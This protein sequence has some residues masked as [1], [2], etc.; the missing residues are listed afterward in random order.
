[1]SQKLSVSLSPIAPWALV[2]LAA[3]AVVALTLWPY[4]R[5]IRESTDR[6]R[7]AVI[8]LRMTAVL[9]CFLAMLRPSVLLLQKV[10]QQAVVLFL[11]DSSSSMKIKD[12]ANNASRWTAARIAAAESQ[13]ALKQAAPSLSLKTYRFDSDV[14]SDSLDDNQ[15]PDGQ[16]TALGAALLEAVKR[17]S[18]SRLAT[19]VLFSDGASNSGIAPA[20]AAQNLKAQGIPVVTVGFG[21]AAAGSTSRD[22]AVTSIR[23]PESVFVKNEVDVRGTLRVRGFARQELDLELMSEGEVRPVARARVTVPEGAETIA[24]EGLRY[25]PQLP[26]EKLLTLRVAPKEGELIASNN[27]FSTFISVLSGGLNVL[28]IQGPGTVWEGKFVSRALDRSREIQTQLKVLL[29]P[30]RG[31]QGGLPDDDF[32]PGKYDVYILGDVPANY[33]TTRQ[34]QSLLAAVQAGAGLIMLGG[35]DSFGDGGWSASPVASILPTFVRPGDGQIEPQG[36]LRV[37]PNLAGLDSYVLQLGSTPQESAAL[38]QALP[39]ISGASRLGRPKEAALVWAETP[40]REPMMVALEVGRGRVISFGGETWPWARGSET[41]RLAHEKFWRQAVLWLAHKEESGESRVELKL[42]RRRAAVGQTVEVSAIARD[43]QDRP[44]PNASYT[45]TVT[46]A[47]GSPEPLE[48]FNQPTGARGSFYAGGE[49][50]VYSVSVI[51]SADG[52]EIG[53][54]TSRFLVFRD[55]RELE[56]P[57]ANIGLLQQI[58]EETGGAFLRPEQLARYFRQID[59]DALTQLES[60]VEYR[61][62]DNFPFLSLFVAALGLEWFLRKRMGWV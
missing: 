16:E 32:A 62:W 28:H 37:V 42:D 59:A 23:A 39:T 41:S 58:A 34:Q 29:R 12:E 55:D 17:E 22:I 36:G 31:D 15:E 27:E 54:A 45:T 44:V 43:A 40:Q 53:R 30:A 50:G 1:M 18:G 9:L 8:G 46:R 19:I 13:K 26:G 35:K 56:N 25:T 5:R 14:R 4:W 48:L 6:R 57:A 49:P 7:F 21:S 10:K 52:K 61:I 60:Q 24:V 2:L 38:W 11:T 3:A 20:S 47:G 33:L 51:A